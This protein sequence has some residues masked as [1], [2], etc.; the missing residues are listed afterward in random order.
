MRERTSERER[1]ESKTKR[2][3]EREREESRKREFVVRSIALTD[4]LLA[5]LIEN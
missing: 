3:R 5:E 2:E 1:E 4:S